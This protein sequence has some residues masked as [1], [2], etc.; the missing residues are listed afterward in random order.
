MIRA[1]VRFRR[2]VRPYS[3]VLVVGAL[4]SFLAIALGVAEP[5][6]LKVVVEDVL[7]GKPGSGPV[8]PHFIPPAH[9][10]HVL[11]G[12]AAAM[13]VVIVLFEAVVEYFSDAMLQT[14]CQRIGNDLR[15]S[16]FAHLQSLSLRYHF[17]NSV[18]DL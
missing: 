4:L 6:P 7:R 12:V 11:L 15:E 9:D 8:I 5:W 18:R 2:F 14:T 16:V 17:E 3:G 1:L 10:P 13:L